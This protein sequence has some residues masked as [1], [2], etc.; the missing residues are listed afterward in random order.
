MP[1][2][3]LWWL[4]ATIF[5]LLLEAQTFNLVS[6]WFAAGSAV[7]LLSC[8]V[9]DSF[10][11]E[12]V[13]FIIVSILCLLASRPLAAKLKSKP[14]ATN[15]DL[16]LGRTA[17]VLTPVSSDETGRVRL[18]GVDWNARSVDGTALAPGEQCRV[19]QIHSTLLIVE[20]MPEQ[21]FAQRL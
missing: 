8:L 21:S 12:C 19:T 3:A 20:P 11:A 14:T 18:D 9:T 7:A 2:H 6:I 16:N 15:A 10:K 17:R 1:I 13:I 5:L 4:A